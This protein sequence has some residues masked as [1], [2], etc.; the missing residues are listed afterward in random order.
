MLEH[1]CVTGEMDAV[2]YNL[3]TLPQLSLF[4]FLIDDQGST[5]GEGKGGEGR[6]Q[7]EY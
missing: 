3:F 1:K 2:K 6:I 4:H 5:D 7:S